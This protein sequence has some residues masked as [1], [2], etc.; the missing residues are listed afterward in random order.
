MQNPRG[1]GPGGFLRYCTLG[2]RKDTPERSLRG[3]PYFS[4]RE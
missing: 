3:V 4:S 1:L 2:N